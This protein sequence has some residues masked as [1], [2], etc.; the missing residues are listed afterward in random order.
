[1]ERR[2]TAVILHPPIGIREEVPGRMGGGLGVKGRTWT[3]DSRKGCSE[4]GRR[5]SVRMV[6]TLPELSVVE[7]RL[8][9]R[10]GGWKPAA[11][12]ESLI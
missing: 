6:Q 3:L 5:G 4:T 12:K 9:V 1:M 10:V 11:E 8:I 7:G 2:H